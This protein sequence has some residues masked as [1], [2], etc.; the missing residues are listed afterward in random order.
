[1]RLQRRRLNMQEY[2]CGL[3]LIYDGIVAVD[4]SRLNARAVNEHEVWLQNCCAHIAH[5]TH[6]PRVLS[7]TLRMRFPVTE[8]VLA[9]KDVDEIIRLA[10]F[11]RIEVVVVTPYPMRWQEA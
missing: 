7:Q 1:M 5:R 8:R 9:Q 11:V 6:A 2:Q 10:S 4:V 3:L